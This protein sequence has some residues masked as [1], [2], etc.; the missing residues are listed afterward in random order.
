[1]KTKKLFLGAIIAFTFFISCDTNETAADTTAVTS[2]EITVESNL[3]IAIDDVSLIVD[4]QYA[5]QQSTTNKSTTVIKSI[6]P[7]CATIT[8]VLTTDTWTRTI[9]FG[10]VGCELKNGN[11][12]KGKIVIS[13]SK[14]YTSPSRTISYSF[15]DFYHNNKLIKGNRS[16][17]HESKSTELLA[18][19]HPV[20]THSVD[21]TVTFGDGKVYTRIGTRVKEMTAGF[22]T[23]FNWEDNVFKVWGYHITTFPNGTKI[24]STIKTPL[25]FTMSCK[26][27][28]ATKGS[29]LIVK[30]NKE[31]L[32]DFGNGD[33]DNLATITVNGVTK[34]IQLKK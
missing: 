19:V 3:D 17:T 24:S 29:I 12:V 11:F 10:T 15:V 13:F 21:M 32:L 18:T 6:L 4:D 33:C 14:N 27:P 20:S 28:F 23:P 30:N 2:D 1:M 22:E 25:Q 26:I 5:M 7:T 8:T 9:D 31:A 16:I 34:E